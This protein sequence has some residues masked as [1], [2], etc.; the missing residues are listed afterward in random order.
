MERF[1]SFKVTGWVGRLEYAMLAFSDDLIVCVCVDN[2][3]K[4]IMTKSFHW[5]GKFRDL[6]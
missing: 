2:E 1:D 3:I 4:L 6:G 5:H